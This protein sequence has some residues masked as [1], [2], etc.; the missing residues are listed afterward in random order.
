MAIQDKSTEAKQGKGFG[1]PSPQSSKQDARQQPPSTGADASLA[2]R[3]IAGSMTQEAVGLV[4]RVLQQQ[5]ELENQAAQAISA[6]RACMGARILDK[7]AADIAAMAGTDSLPNPQSAANSLG[8][9]LAA[10]H[11]QE[12]WRRFTP[13]QMAAHEGLFLSPA[14]MA[15]KQLPGA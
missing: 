11:Q 8:Q 3:A 6:N 15:R 4:G 12:N 9:A 1:G 10:V 2:V 7:A 5:E 14:E 13:D